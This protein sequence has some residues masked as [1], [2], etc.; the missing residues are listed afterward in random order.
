MATGKAVKVTR[1]SVRLRTLVLLRQPT[2]RRRSQTSPAVSALQR[3]PSGYLRGEGAGD[4]KVAGSLLA[5][6]LLSLLDSS[7]S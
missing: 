5:F 6:D 2:A 3:L 4:G 7:A 1:G